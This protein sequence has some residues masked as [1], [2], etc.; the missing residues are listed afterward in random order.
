MTP[1]RPTM[2][3]EDVLNLRA[4]LD[5]PAGDAVMRQVRE[6][7]QVQPLTERRGEN[8]WR[9]CATGEPIPM[10]TEAACEDPLDPLRP[11]P[12][13]RPPETVARV[14][15]L[16]PVMLRCWIIVALCF[17]GWLISVVVQTIRSHS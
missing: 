15:S 9:D 11:F 6:S 4:F 17:A 7:Y 8:F 14:V 5:S 3:A 16:R 12:T 10:D 2:S 13:P 1:P